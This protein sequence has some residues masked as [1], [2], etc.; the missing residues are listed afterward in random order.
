[1]A[2]VDA[3]GYEAATVGRPGHSLSGVSR[4]AFYRHLPDLVPTLVYVTLAPFLSAEEA[5]E[6]AIG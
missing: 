1:M 2:T 4:S 3:K 6:I 5:Y